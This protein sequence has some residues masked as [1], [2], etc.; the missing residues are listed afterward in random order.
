VKCVEPRARKVASP[1]L[2]GDRGD[3][4][5]SSR[6]VGGRLSP[7]SHYLTVGSKT[8]NAPV[9]EAK[10]FSFG[11]LRSEKFCWKGFLFS[12][13]FSPLTIF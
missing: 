6:W 7:S 11:R 4:P 1:P 13:G 12:R 8:E 10:L 2:T 9:K 3:I 5:E